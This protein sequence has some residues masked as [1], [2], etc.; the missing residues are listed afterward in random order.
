M[1]FDQKSYVYFTLT[2]GNVTGSMGFSS[3]QDN[4]GNHYRAI[5]GYGP[6]GVPRSFNINFSPAEEIYRAGKNQRVTV[7]VNNTAENWLLVDYLRKSSL[8]EGS[9]N[10]RGVPMYK[11]IDEEKDAGILVDAKRLRKKASDAAFE[12]ESKPK[13][14]AEI[15]Q[16]IGEF[17]DDK[18]IQFSSILNFA[19]A[20]PKTFL[21]YVESP[22][23][24][25]R[26]LIKKG[27]S[28][29]ELKMKGKLIVWKNETVGIDED[30]ATQRLI[31]EPDL[32]KAIQ[33]AV[34]KSK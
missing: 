15:A 12:L 28:T 13:E 4:D 32:M 3:F 14:L 29:G 16:L 22:D 31:R 23:R 6:S 25:A 18:N 9:P 5:N 8:C 17:R 19:D 20:D 7:L 27:L 2:K 21:S 26:A 33:L 34:K 1:A 11:E 10:L 24:Q 30:E